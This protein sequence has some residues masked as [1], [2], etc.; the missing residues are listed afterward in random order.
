VFLGEV[1]KQFPRKPLKL[2]VYVS[3][4]DMDTEECEAL[5]DDLRLSSHAPRTH[6][7]LLTSR[8]MKGWFFGK[9]SSKPNRE[10]R[11]E[12]KEK[13]EAA[14]QAFAVVK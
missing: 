1:T 3:P 7:S 11:R 9:R 13:C 12:L 4:T 8:K 5:V 14:T 2:L 10:L 6:V